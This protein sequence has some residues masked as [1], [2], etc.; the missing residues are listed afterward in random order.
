ME[1]PY[2]ELYGDGCTW[3]NNPNSPNYRSCLS[4]GKAGG[5]I[6]VTYQVKILDIPAIN[7]EPLTSLVY[8]FSGSSYHYN[9]DI[10]VTARYAYIADP[11]LANITKMFTPSTTGVGGVSRLTITIQNLNA[12][13]V[14][15]YNFLDNLPN[16]MKV[17]AT[18][19]AST[20]N[21]GSPTFAPA[22]NA[23]SLS[24]SGGTIAAN[25]YCTIQVDVTTTEA[26]TYTNTTEH[27]YVGGQD[28]NKY[29]SAD[30]TVND[31][32]APPA[33]TPGLVLAYWDFG[34]LLNPT[35][36][37]TYQ[38]SMVTNATVSYAGN[39][40]SALTLYGNAV[41]G[42]SLT[43][44]NGSWPENP[45]I[46]GYPTGG[47]SPYFEFLLDTSN[48]TDVR[49]QFDLNIEGNWANSANNHIYVWSNADGGVFD[50][51]PIIDVTNISKGNW[52][53]NN[54][55]IASM[56]GSSTTAF[57]INEIGAKS[58]GTMPSVT[59]DNVIITGCGVPYPS[60]TKAFSPDPIAVNGTSTLL[61]TLTNESSA[62]LTDVTFTCITNLLSV[63]SFHQP[64]RQV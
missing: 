63:H 17:A 1:P 62:P 44:I 50:T 39:L 2:E 30:L 48:F 24:F 51:T 8:D 55:A 64:L 37:P 11:T 46:G 36:N 35:Y 20:T 29:A 14:T 9:Q 26:A 47:A 22:T 3:E 42:W 31:A 19:N 6:S 59:L 56:T 60:L 18:P 15:G 38:S 45:I 33:C 5:T 25:G 21:C 12:A 53:P 57:R 41:P 52:Y 43:S 4:T 27:L 7:P 23:T 28:T 54:I 61:F 10:G 40:N 58:T 32:P 49:I 16:N 13:V 34:T